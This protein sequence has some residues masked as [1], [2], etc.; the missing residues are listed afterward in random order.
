MKTPWFKEGSIPAS[1]TLRSPGDFALVRARSA[2]VTIRL[3][4]GASID[5]D[6]T[7]NVYY[8]PD[9]TN[10]DSVVFTSFVIAYTVSTTKQR[11]IALNVPEHGYMIISVVNGSSADTLT[12][13]VAWYSVQSWPTSG[14]IGKGAVYVDT[15]EEKQIVEKEAR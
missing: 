11:T 6:T 14:D 4:F 3:T 9:G 1:G 10:W 5:A 8:S 7:V 13:I 2:S 12:N 15:G